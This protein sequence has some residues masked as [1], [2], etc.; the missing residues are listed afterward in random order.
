MEHLQSIHAAIKGKAPIVAI[1]VEGHA[2]ICIRHKMLKGGLRGVEVQSIAIVTMPD[3]RRGL[4]V[5]GRA[6]SVKTSC[7]FTAIDRR[8]ASQELS[9][10]SAK[11]RAKAEKRILQ[12]A[13]SPAEVKAAKLAAIERE[14][15]ARA[16]QARREIQFI[17]SAVAEHVRR[18]STIQVPDRADLTTRFLT[19]RRTRH[20]RKAAAAVS[21]AIKSLRSE[22]F[23]LAKSK[24]RRRYHAPKRFLKASEAAK[25]IGIVQRL[26]SLKM[27]HSELFPPLFNATLGI[28]VPSFERRPR[29]E[30]GYSAHSYYNRQSLAQ[31]LREARITLAALTPPPDPLPVA[32]RSTFCH[33]YIRAEMAA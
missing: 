5:T 21:H 31:R 3:G 17:V 13:L 29:I 33:P 12:G 9:K 24:V 6:G 22:F 15:D 4:R 32:I 7:T 25:V 2:P 20:N 14:G 1:P 23:A 16:M 30:Y 27:R 8:T 18:P 26:I 11:E 10:W 19:W 28:Y